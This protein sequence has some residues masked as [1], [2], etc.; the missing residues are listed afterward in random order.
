MSNIKDKLVSVDDLESPKTTA[1]LKVELKSL[2]DEEAALDLEIKREKVRQ[3]REARQAKLDE[4]RER[5][6]SI[7]GMLEQRAR[8]QRQCT[9]RKGGSGAN[10]VIQGQGNDS[11]Y[12]IIPHM[13]PSGRLMIICSR[14]GQ[15]EYSVD[16]ITRVPATKEYER[17][18]QFAQATDNTMS[19]SSLFVRV[20]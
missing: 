9:H 20:S 16:P 11:K 2:E 6:E 12:S 13:L 15:E 19:G 18:R 8:L 7:R 4:S 1:E 14:C 3:I 17:F 10:A 5:T